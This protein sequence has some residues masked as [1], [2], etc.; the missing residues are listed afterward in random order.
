MKVVA[1][2]DEHGSPQEIGASAVESDGKWQMTITDPSYEGGEVWLSYRAENR[3][4]RVVDQQNKVTRWLTSAISNPSM[5]QDFGHDWGNGQTGRPGVGE[6]HYRAY[7]LWNQ[8]YWRGGFDVATN[9]QLKIYFPN[10]FFNCGGKSPW[11][12]ALKDEA[13][14]IASHAKDKDTVQHE[15]AHT[16]TR[17]NWAAGPSGCCI[18]HSLDTCYNKGLGLDE[19]YAT[20]MPFWV[21]GPTRSAPPPELVK[22]WNLETPHSKVCKTPGANNE[23]WVGAT[24][25]DLYDSRA[26]GKDVLWFTHPGAVHKIALANGPT[27]SGQSLGMPDL[28]THYRNAA[29]S[30]H[31]TNIDNIFKQ[32]DTD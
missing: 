6:V 28:R 5:N 2:S 9:T 16:V 4:F 11:S 8:T 24:F 18:G 13:W 3:Y 14:V 1:I 20:F 25:W 12:C 19:G 7:E 22:G 23:W 29:S 15:L 10:T 27:C 17:R 26:D 30:G 31:Q 32:N 21:Q